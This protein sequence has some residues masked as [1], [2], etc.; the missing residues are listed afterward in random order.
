M[1]PWHLDFTA[2][3]FT[4]G[5][6]LTFCTS[7]LTLFGMAPPQAIVT[8]FLSG[9][10]FHVS[11]NL[12]TADIQVTVERPMIC[13][14]HAAV[15]MWPLSLAFRTAWCWEGRRSA[16]KQRDVMT[17]CLVR[18]DRYGLQYCFFWHLSLSCGAN[19]GIC[20]VTKV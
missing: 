11:H 8:L 5:L 18:W 17:L 12:E 15:N 16:G 9:Q 20:T 2:L 19:A 6:L 10:H 4:G 7:C 14:A 13:C 1:G 3:L